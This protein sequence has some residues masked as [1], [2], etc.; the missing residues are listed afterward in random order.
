MAKQPKPEYQTP[1]YLERAY[2]LLASSPQPETAQPKLV[3]DEGVMNTPLLRAAR[4]L[5]SGSHPSKD[6]AGPYMVPAD[7]WLTLQAEVME[8]LRQAAARDLA[9]PAQ[10]EAAQSPA[11]KERDAIAE[12]NH[13]QWLA[14]GQCAALVSACH[15]LSAESEEYDFDDGLGRGAQQAYWDEFDSALERASEALDQAN[16]E[17]QR[18]HATQ[19]VQP[20]QPE[21]APADDVL[22]ALELSPETFR[23]EGGVI[24][25][26]KL[27]AAILHPYNYLPPDHWMQARF[28]KPGGRP[29]SEAAPAV[30]HVPKVSNS[31]P[32][33]YSDEYGIAAAPEAPA[34]AELTG[35]SCR[36]DKDDNRVQ[37]CA[38]HQGWL[39]VVHEWAARA[40]DAEWK[41]TLALEAPPQAASAEDGKVYKD[42]ADRYFRD[43]QAAQSAGEVERE[44]VSIT[45]F[46]EFT[47]ASD[48]CLLSTDQDMCHQAKALR[49]FAMPALRWAEAQL[50]EHR[51]D[52]RRLDWLD[53]KNLRFKMGWQVSEAPSGNVNIK[54]VI[55]L[56]G[57]NPVP[58]R[59]A[60][61][62]ALSHKESQR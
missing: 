34:Q 30:A 20:S 19:F 54:S 46:D 2:E 37:T 41:L 24:N 21:A 45:S 48:H 1:E 5:V 27:R 50:T 59:D 32:V 9:N 8:S 43:T 4:L 16:K 28:S 11:E 14:L 7:L 51:K 25:K 15:R 57:R 42:I 53:A 49:D 31:R 55:F 39:D 26:G 52:T 61:D 56:D 23:T 3:D 40:K 10:P 29:L 58:I 36:W 33:L 6:C 38:R 13:Q 12:L 44:P 62:A 22:E 60:I 18:I 35:C 47:E 17:T